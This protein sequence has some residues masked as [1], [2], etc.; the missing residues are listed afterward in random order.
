MKTT[1]H[2]TRT[3]PAIPV[4]PPAPSMASSLAI[5]AERLLLLAD[6]AAGLA[7]AAVKSGRIEEAM[8][9]LDQAAAAL[10]LARRAGADTD[11]RVATLSTLRV[12]VEE[13]GR[14]T[15]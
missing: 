8:H 11:E 3:A 14:I 13:I 5:A 9:R 7:A 12:V 10:S 4:V 1:K 6:G 2:I 15:A